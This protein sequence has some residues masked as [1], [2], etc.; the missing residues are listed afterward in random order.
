MNKNLKPFNTL[1][2]E[3]QRKI[4]SAGGKKSVEVRR[5][6][7]KLKEILEI[8]LS[9]TI[10]NNNGEEKEIKE[11]IMLKVVKKAL[12]GDQKAIDYITKMIEEEPT[13]KHELVGESLVQKVFIT[14]D[15]VSKVDKK[16]DDILKKHE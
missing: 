9:Q 11:A 10:K 2:E 8:A 3:E 5:E 4:A 16:I 13:T 14:K 1:T 7:K 6:K 12:Q 15:D